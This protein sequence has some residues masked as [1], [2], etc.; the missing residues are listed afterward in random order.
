LSRE[1]TVRQLESWLPVAAYVALIFTLSSIPDLAPPPVVPYMDKLAHAAEYGILGLLLARAFRLSA[2]GLAAVAA[3]V[4]TLG[5]G[6]MIGFLD[7]SFQG[8]VGRNSSLLDWGA[9]V[10]GLVVALVLFLIAAR[11]EDRARVREDAGS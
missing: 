7:E 9:D 3:A 6:A 8:T 1:E 2:P 4:L 11:L 10:A 5:T